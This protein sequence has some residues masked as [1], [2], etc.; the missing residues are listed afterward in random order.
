VSAG[1]GRRDLPDATIS[2]A[3]RLRAIA[4]RLLCVFAIAALPVLGT[5]AQPAPSSDDTLSLVT[6]NLWHDK[7]DWPKREP[8]IVAA[9]RELQPDVILLQEVIQHEQLQNQAR[10]IAEALGYR[11]VFVTVDPPDK[12]L[13]FGNAILSRHPILAQDW[14]ALQPLDDYRTIARVRIALG[15]RAV[16]VYTTHLHW[17]E[18]GGAIRARQVADALDFIA[19][20]GDGAPIILAG[21]L[22]AAMDAPELQP[23]LGPFFDAYAARH[24]D[25]KAGDR[26]HSTLNLSQYAAR[27][28]DQILPQRDAFTALDA[29]VILDRPDA[30]GVFASDHYGVFAR[31]RLAPPSGDAARRWTDRTLNADARADALVAQM[32]GNEK[33]RLIR[34]DFGYKVAGHGEPVGAIGSAAFVPANARL[35]IPSLQETDAGQGVTKDGL[36][37]RGATALPSML[38]VAASW[39]PAIAEAGGAMIGRQAWRKGFNVLLAGSVNLQRDPR[40]GRNFEYTGEDP[41]LAGTIAGAAIRGV[42][43]QH[44]VSTTKHF[45]IN[46]YETS[47]NTHDAVIGREALRESDLL[48]F[49]FALEGGN[50]GSVMCAYNRIE[51][52]HACEHD[53]LLNQVLKRDWA[54]P[55]WVMSDWGG[56]HSA[57]AAANAGLD[58]QSAGDAFDKQ[59]Y[60]DAPLRAALGRGEIAQARIDDM[61]RRI[62]RSLFAVGAFDHPP[63]ALAL[64]WD[65]DAAVSQRAIEAGAVLLR[66]RDDLLP[67]PRTL[68]SVAVIGGHADVGVLSGGGS[69]A[70]QPPG[71]NA[72]PGL[73]PAGWPGPPLYLPS[74]PLRAIAALAP[75]TRVGYVD[76]RDI[77]A[78]A[79][80]ARDADV[81]VVFATQWAAEA[82]DNPT[83]AL[84]DAQD[85][86]IAAVTAANPRTVVVL[87][88][89]GAVRMPW[90]DGSGAVLQAWYPGLRGG[91]AIARL[92][93]GDA[94]PSGRLPMTWPRDESQ[95]PRPH[96]EGAGL[97]SKAPPMETVDY[98]IEGANVGY[99]WFAARRI[100]PLFPFGFGL[101]YTRFA[102]RD[103]ALRRDGP[104]LH[105][106]ADV[107]NT[108]ARDG[109]D[110][111]QAYLHLPD[112]HATP[113]RLLG[114]R[115]VALKAGER[116][117]V[118]IEADP[119]L[120]AD[121]DESGRAWRIRA[122]AYRVT[123]G[124]SATDAAL[125]QDLVL[126][127]LAVKPESMAPMPR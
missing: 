106:Y 72:V 21:D 85:A 55:G 28:I 17:T 64:E 117:R 108:G 45:A 87:E 91:E 30:A 12:P 86:L 22:N 111:V 3:K 62:L 32:R 99:K 95:L 6:L 107:E 83:M 16:D 26:A 73:P 118:A 43:S 34:S 23:L 54:F 125:S 47:R 74:S 78:A 14:R 44:V 96:I 7:G 121:Y 4:T 67:L 119:R 71:G 122:G 94:S 42:Q 51:G 84:P 76:G 39:D 79:A 70:V 75:D 123:V 48:A 66:N 103:L 46:D 104:R 52:I 19:S 29:R 37:G 40:G 36:S 89:S 33:F 82:F 1:G 77:A 60:F 88:T 81:A 113:L 92:L 20:S 58:Q 102:Y 24:P 31:L 25:M 112:G 63:Q 127:D 10:T 69:S 80:A 57:A 61:A 114:W 41:L 49:E 5:G 109:S 53:W 98:R 13:R 8:Q 101:G 90:L 15:A 97:H 35:G 116:R 18:G 105:V 65:A 11:F 59:V 27:H 93:F 38:G 56:V 115:K 126:P 100:E 68:K 50:P 9:L 124:G 110:V 2:A 120:L